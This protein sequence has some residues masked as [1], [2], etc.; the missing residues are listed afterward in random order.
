MKTEAWRRYLR[1]WRADVEGDVDEELRF[2]VEMREREYV[3]GGLSPDE[4]HAEALLRF[5]NVAE[6][7]DSC[8]Q[9]G[10][11]RERRM[12]FVD[13][14]YGVRNDVVFAV[15]QLVRNPSFTIA[16]VLTLALGIGA[17]GLILG[18]VNAVLLRPLPGIDEPDRVVTLTGTSVSYPAFRDFRDANPAL[19]DLAAFAERSTAVSNGKL[20]EVAEVGAVTGSYFRVLGVK[21]SRGRLLND[22]DDIPG[23][24]PVAVVTDAFARRFFP[25]NDN[26]V[27]RTID[28]NG[29]PVIIVGVAARNFHGMYIDSPE[30]LWVSAH[31]WMGLAPS[32]YSGRT[33][34]LR[35]WSWLSVVGRLKPHAAIAQAKAAFNRSA[36]RQEAAYPDDARRIMQEVAASPLSTAGA[37]AL[38]NMEHKTAVRA[39]ALVM[40][41]VMIVLLIACANVANLLLARSMARRREFGVRIAI[42]ARG[43]RMVRQLLTETGVLALVA[44]AFGLLL[45]R[46]GI[47]VLAHLQL[48]GGISIAQLGVH[49]D[50]RVTFYTIVVA[51]VAS[52]L[53]GTAPALKSA[54]ADLTRALKDGAAGAGHSRSNAQ[55]ALLIAQVALSLILL[56]G[57]GLFTR[58]L[59]R[60]L[61]TDSGIDGSHVAVA[62]VNIGL[63]RA[64]SAHAGQ[65]YDAV[66][67]QLANVPGIRFAS[68]A[69]ALPLDAGSD[70]YGFSIDGFTPPTDARPQLQVSAV[71]PHYFEAFSIPLKRG[72]AFTQRDNARAPHV[73]I[74][75]ETMAK[76]YWNGADPIGKRIVFSQDTVVIVGVVRDVKYHE[77]HEPAQ[78][79]VYRVLDQHLQESGLARVSL[80]VRTTGDPRTAFSVVRRTLHDVAPEVPLYD[81]ST[82][83]QRSGHTIFAQRL[84]TSVLGLFGILALVITA[85]GIYGVV[86]YGVTQ[87]TREMGIRIA[88][89]ARTLSVLRLVLVNNI[90]TILLGV[91]IGLLMS[92]ALTRTVSSFLFGVSAMDAITFAA[93]SAILLAVGAAATLIPAVRATRVDPVIAL[94]SE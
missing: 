74:I 17:N 15:R 30:P 39:A 69:S 93:A 57:A 27:G 31:T 41:V 79:F 66:I 50:G 60:A 13:F 29:S 11:R 25:D 55:Q 12:R 24:A 49:V 70:S 61:A 53:F 5:G 59:Q 21:A 46:I 22:R 84:G 1:F 10:H 16:A 42:G 78:P 71:S 58:S 48:A 81:L 75:N 51:L 9:I 80:A 64:D 3:A 43:T 63:T 36:A 88:L 67:N 89:G 45:T 34:E 6:V 19:S 52:V 73:A 91:V 56:I 47:R 44:A 85:I 32:S 8:Y 76:R 38:A 62:S 40:V 20:T 37:A 94:R 77:L 4:A 7:R 65:I 14:A 68:W 23:A 18:L 54:R 82:F 33:V 35:D 86:G 92:V 72:R 87:R 83:E 28:L 26:V 90:T 2:H